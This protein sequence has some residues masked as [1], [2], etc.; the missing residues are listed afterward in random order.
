M[1]EEETVRQETREV[2]GTGGVVEVK[3]QHCF[4]N[5]QRG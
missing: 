1:A 4:A 5:T 2:S 3:A